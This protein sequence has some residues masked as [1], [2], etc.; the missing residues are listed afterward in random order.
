M[1]EVGYHR[2]EVGDNDDGRVHVMPED[3]VHLYSINCSCNPEVGPGD[4][5]K[6]F[7]FV[8]RRRVWKCSHVVKDASTN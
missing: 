6:H 1:S 3:E 2:E 5:V 8:V 7:G 4:M